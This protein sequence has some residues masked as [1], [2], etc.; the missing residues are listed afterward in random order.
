MSSYHH[1]PIAAKQAFHRERIREPAVTCPN[2]DVQTTPADLIEHVRKRC[3]GPRE[4][5]PGSKW[6][7]LREALEVVPRGTLARWTKTGVVRV[8]GERQER[9]YLLRDLAVRIARRR[10]SQ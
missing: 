4:P 3:T 5:G 10:Q 9:M 8:R 7:T 2:C 1:L 6:I